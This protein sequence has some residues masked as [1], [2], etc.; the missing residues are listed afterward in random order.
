MDVMKLREAAGVVRDETIQE[1]NEKRVTTNR[2]DPPVN[3]TTTRHYNTQIRQQANTP[4]TLT[5]QTTLVTYATKQKLDEKR[6]GSSTSSKQEGKKQ[7]EPSSRFTRI[8]EAYRC[9]GRSRKKEGAKKNQ[10]I[11]I[12]IPEFSR[13]HVSIRRGMNGG[14]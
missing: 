11:S 9:G 14:A 5:N 13:C 10:R 6:S 12:G 3:P 7:T 8:Q 4:S 1:E 2:P